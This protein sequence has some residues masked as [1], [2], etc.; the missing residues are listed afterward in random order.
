MSFMPGSLVNEV[1]DRSIDGRK[2]WAIPSSGS[3]DKPRS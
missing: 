1:D 2:E 3:A